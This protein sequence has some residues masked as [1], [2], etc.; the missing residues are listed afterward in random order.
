MSNI[1]TIILLA[2]GIVI[3]FLAPVLHGLGASAVSA[4][5]E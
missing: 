5:R 2:V 3:L 4:S 1:A